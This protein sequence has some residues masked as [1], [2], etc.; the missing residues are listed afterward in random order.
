MS[1]LFQ[2]GNRDRSAKLM[3]VCFSSSSGSFF[4][5]TFI[6]SYVGGPY[7]EGALAFFASVYVATDTLL[8]PAP[9]AN[10]ELPLALRNLSLAMIP[11]LSMKLAGGADYPLQAGQLALG[12]SANFSLSG[13]GNMKLIPGGL[14]EAGD[15]PSSS[16]GLHYG[17]A[18]LD[19]EL[20]LW[21]G[22][23][24]QQRLIGTVLSQPVDQNQQFLI[25]LLDIGVN[26]SSGESPFSPPA[27]QGL[28]AKGNNT[29]SKGLPVLM[30]PGAPYLF[31][32]NST[33]AAITANLPVI[34]NSTFAL[35][36]WDTTSPDVARIIT[37]P[38][39]LSFTF[40]VY[41]DN[42]NVTI[43]VPFALLNLT[44]D[45]TIVDT[46]TQYFPCQEPHLDGRYSLGRAFLQAAFLGANWD[47]M[48]QEWYLAQAPG[49]NIALQPSPVPFPSSVP[50]SSPNQWDATWDGHWTALQNMSIMEKPSST[51]SGLSGGA[52]AGIV[53]GALVGLISTI[54]GV[55]FFL[56]RRSKSTQDTKTPSVPFNG[57]AE[58]KSELPL[59][60]H[61]K[62][63]HELA[64]WEQ[65]L[66]ELAGPQKG[67]NELEGGT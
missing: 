1:H 12:P 26:V 63:F 35:Y 15:L 34:Y 47:K 46:P 48:P 25:N 9:G 5:T 37:S 66:P 50:S 29:I 52:I 31:L 44:L 43:N 13:T 32:P 39:Y 7:E 16:F 67:V 28:L 42:T 18:A 17:S 10:N 22:G 57:R 60:G 61:E 2:T 33:C 62:R 45:T 64:N 36:F 27:Q 20:S 41:D 40:S 55:W 49:P 51:P 3:P 6:E 24:D 65:S 19:L 54:A 11:Q 56:R 14:A 8:L 53:I 23:Y 4:K 21:L 38:S 59:E 58:F 30:N